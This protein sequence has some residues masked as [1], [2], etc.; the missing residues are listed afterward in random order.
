MKLVQEKLV[1]EHMHLIPRL[2]SK[3][4]G[5]HHHADKEELV[6][7][8]Y[9]ALVKAAINFQNRSKFSTYMY[10][11]VL[12][13]MYDQLSNQPYN[14]VKRMQL[15]SVEALLNSPA[16]AYSELGRLTKILTERITINPTQS[17]LYDAT[18]TRLSECIPLLR[19][20]YQYIMKRKV[21]D[22]ATNQE[23]ATELM[24]TPMAVAKKFQK[25]TQDLKTLYEGGEVRPTRCNKRRRSRE[26]KQA[27]LIYC[28]C[29][30]GTLIPE[31]KPNGTK[32]KYAN[33]HQFK[34]FNPEIASGLKSTQTVVDGQKSCS[35]CKTKKDL[36]EFSISKHYSSGRQAA[37]KE[38]NSKKQKE[39]RKKKRY[40][41]QL[42]YQ[43]K[44][45]N[46]DNV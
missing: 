26:L 39:V 13:A 20:D 17:V 16:P 18:R 42:E 43:H 31:K 35:I 40:S 23:L 1:L 8:G 19:T 2:A 10:K 15:F 5:T 28:A 32:R 6:G 41:A 3:V 36:D 9:L 11:A 25:A 46:P 34:H 12:G 38:C 45:D 4:K 37:C 27:E 14:D 44:L 22:E 30:C 29:E 24:L 21:V 33:G 7:E